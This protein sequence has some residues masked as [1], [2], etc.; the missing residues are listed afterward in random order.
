[1]ILR[2][3]EQQ[4]LKQQR[5]GSVYPQYE[6]YCFSNIPAAMQYLFGLR[7]TSSLSPIFD[8]AG[9]APARQQKV[10]ALL[11]DGFGWNQWL[12]YADRYE[13]L[14]R[15]AEKGVLA[16]V[17]AVFPSTTSSAVTTIHSGLTPQEHG[18]PEWWVYFEELQQII[19][20]LLF[21]P[22]DG[23]R[24]DQLLESGASPRILFDGNTW[25]KA[26]GESGIPA[27]NL[28]NDA[29]KNSAYSSVVLKD[30]TV[31]P[32]MEAS[33]LVKTLCSKLAEVASP[34]YFLAYW[35]EID[36]VAHDCGVHSEPYLAE[37]ELLMP[38]LQ[39][40]FIERLPGKVAEETVLMVF[41]DHGQINVDPKDTIYLNKFPKLVENLR[42][43]SDG[44]KIL[45]WGS[46]RDVFLAVE[47]GRLDEMV[48]FLT[49][50]LE[51]KVRVLKTD[52]ALRDGMFGHG[53][54]HAKFRSRLG[55]IL[56]LPEGNL[57]L[58]YERPYRKKFRM[59]GM[60]GGLSPDEMLVPL[61]VARISDLQ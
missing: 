44:E 45:P 17:T 4:I 31:V 56:L 12:K 25:Y 3:I 7:A 16:P 55:D 13:F 32:F 1:M 23:D 8:K 36:G 47:E 26:L 21:R 14:K 37:L 40:E 42:T 49:E 33:G 59:L 30:S 6:G 46:A 54:L 53:D 11:L 22:L 34:A 58:W 5:G 15:F 29:F 52:E 48:G 19:I 28:I 60:H 57:T 20:T 41:A 10:V 51:G 2:D 9:I 18:L 38:L 50:A 61:A 24:V 39:K 35:G 27:F 43:G